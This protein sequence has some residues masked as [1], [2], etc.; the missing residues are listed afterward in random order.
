LDYTP[1]LQTSAPVEVGPG[2][3][4]HLHAELR[5]SGPQATGADVS[6]VLQGIGLNLANLLTLDIPR[7]SIQLH[8]GHKPDIDA[9]VGNPAFHGALAFIQTLYDLLPAGGF[10][11]PPAVTV[12]ATGIHAGYDF[13]VPAVAV[14]VFS[15][16]NLGVAAEL[17]VPFI[18]DP[19]EL[20]VSISSREKPFLLTVMAIGGGGWAVV[21][22]GPKG[23]VS[24]EVGLEFGAAIE[25]DLGV[26]SGGVSVAAGIYI[27]L[28][29]TGD[30]LSGFFRIRGQVDV[31]GL[32]SASLELTLTLH[33]DTGPGKVWGE[34]T[35][36]ICIHICFFSTSV[37]V[38]CRRTF[39]SSSGDPTL[40]D[41]MTST[42]ALG[43]GPPGPVSGRAGTGRGAAAGTTAPA[44]WVSYCEAFADD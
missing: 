25:I 10:G 9:A 44:A 28:D 39:A 43:A 41:S 22:L 38:G 23:L 24:V 7:V 12:D 11:D 16:E 37:S 30:S 18:G 5:H 2:G 3:G 21:A 1:P 15:L 36:T 26:A 35:L 27:L 40:A 34:A 17:L 14:G 8:D 6:C 31:L 4:L 32:V 20:D 42:H 19:M 13:A 33:Y 29:G